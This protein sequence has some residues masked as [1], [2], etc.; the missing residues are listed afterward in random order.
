VK[1]PFLALGAR[2]GP[3]ILGGGVRAWFIACYS[4]SSPRLYLLPSISGR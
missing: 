2:F 1:G 4:L 3:L